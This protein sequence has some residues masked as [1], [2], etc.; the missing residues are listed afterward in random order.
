MIEKIFR[1]FEQ[2]LLLYEMDEKELSNKR[3]RSKLLPFY[4]WETKHGIEA[5]FYFDSEDFLKNRPYPIV[6]VLDAYGTVTYDIDGT[7]VTLFDMYGEEDENVGRWPIE[8]KFSVVCT[9]CIMYDNKIEVADIIVN[10]NL[11]PRKNMKLAFHMKGIIP[12]SLQ[13]FRFFGK[14]SFYFYPQ[15][16][17]VSMRLSRED[18]ANVPEE[19]KHKKSEGWASSPRVKIQLEAV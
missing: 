9:V 7:N 13:G 6:E 19:L 1:I 4:R 18:Y 3:R 17:F 16:R 11:L 10:K 12:S 15:E 2:H 14:R 5:R 8:K